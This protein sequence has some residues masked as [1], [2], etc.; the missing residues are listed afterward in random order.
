MVARLA[1]I[2]HSLD[3]NPFVGEGPLRELRSK[4]AHPEA[5]TTDIELWQRQLV[6]GTVELQFGNEETALKEMSRVYEGIPNLRN[7]LPLYWQVEAI[8]RVGVT[9][10]RFGE[11]QNCCLRHNGDSCLLPIRGGGIHTKTEGSRGAVRYFTEAL[12]TA[13]P[14]SRNYYEALWLLNIAYMTLGE[15]PDKVPQEYLIPKERFLSQESFPRFPNVA[16]KVGLDRF[17]AAGGVI[18]DDFDNDDDIDV[19]VSAMHPG[20]QLM[21]HENLGDGTFRD[22]T[23]AAGLIGIT[24]GL[25]IIQADYNNDGWV[26]VLVP[27]GGWL[28][29]QGVHPKSLLRNNGDGTFTDVTYDAGLGEVDYPS[30]T[31]AWGDYDLDGDLDLY[32][33]NEAIGRL[34]SPS[35]LFRNNGDGTFTDVAQQAGVTNDR[36]AKAVLW[37]DYDNDRW[38]DIF[39]SNLDGLERLYRNNGNGTFVDVAVDCGVAGTERT[40]PAWFWDFNNDGNLDIFLTS[41]EGATDQV[42]KFYLGVAYERGVPHLFRGEGNGRFVSVGWEM[43]LREPMLPM[44]CNFGDLDNDGWLDCYIGTGDPS[45]AQ[46]VPNKMYRNVEGKK[47]SDV[48]EAGG[49]SSLQKGHGVAFADLDGDGDQDVFE[50]MGGAVPGDKY[51]SALYEN[52][53]FGNSWV[54]IRLIGTESNRS[55]IGTRIRIDFQDGPQSRSVYRWVGSGGSFGA[56]PLRQSIGLGK[57]TKIDRVEIYWP[58]TDKT[59]EF[60][61]LEPGKLYRIT[62]GEGRFEAVS[63]PATRLGG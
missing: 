47:F 40:F 42:A 4:V 10:L 54:A 6:L 35:Q 51:Y 3:Y 14:D 41:Y 63:K 11:T 31:A 33:G 61:E 52:P 17:A 32:V 60:H 5:G 1:E 36:F 34:S 24:G 49:F 53:G 48:S 58:K 62:E 44:G 22:R 56:N 2:S 39:I 37:G 21:Y 30:Q 26:D 20:E 25:N 18:A 23:E 16:A 9:S 12:R 28:G 57:A 59:Q 7:K 45:Y 43:G 46:L 19:M 55:A 8:F 29:D 13:R 15:Y 27:R 38:P 50:Q